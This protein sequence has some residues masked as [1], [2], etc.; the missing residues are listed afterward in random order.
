MAASASTDRNSCRRLAPTTRNSANSRVRWPTVIENV[1]KIVN[2]PTKSEMKANTSN[3]VEKNERA[4]SAAL[5]DSCTT[6]CPVTTS[7]PGRQCPGDVVLDNGLVCPRF[8]HDVD[9]IELAHLPDDGLRSREGKCSQGGAGQVGGVAELG[10]AGDCVRLRR[11]GRQDA[12]GLARPEVVLRRRAGVHYDIVRGRRRLPF[13]QAELGNLPVGVESDAISGG[14]VVRDRVPVRGHELRISLDLTEGH[15][16]ARDV[17]HGTDDGLGQR[18]AH[19]GA[20][21]TSELGDSPDLEVDLL[22]NIAEQTGE[23]V[24]ERVGEHER[25]GDK[26]NAEHDRQ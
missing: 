14:R 4:W 22:V 25:P 10:D 15:R 7:A 17:A 20:R 26:G 5:V 1:L 2:A 6:V 16:H 24:V 8:G 13:D 23:R 18:V 11:P 21:V 3:A 19:R 12:D 9:V